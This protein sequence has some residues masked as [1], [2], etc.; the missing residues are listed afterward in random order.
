MFLKGA[1]VR[2]IHDD[3]IE[4]EFDKVLRKRP[5]MRGE[6]TKTKMRVK[7]QK[8]APELFSV[9]HETA[10]AAAEEHLEMGAAEEKVA[11]EEE[12]AAEEKVAAEEEEVPIVKKKRTYKPRKPKNI[13]V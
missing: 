1:T 3:N 4:A 12:V 7:L 11:V 2:D 9:V 10:A 13:P 5:H 8:S 6:I